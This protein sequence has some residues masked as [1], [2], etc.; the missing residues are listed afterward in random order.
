MRAIIRRRSYIRIMHVRLIHERV[1][2]VCVCAVFGM[3]CVLRRRVSSAPWNRCKNAAGG[4]VVRVLSPRAVR[5]KRS[6]GLDIITT[7]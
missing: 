3:K 1:C 6:S 2:V 7:R 4:R 5:E